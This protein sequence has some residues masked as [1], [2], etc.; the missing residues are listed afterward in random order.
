[1]TFAERKTPENHCCLFGLP[2][3]P[4]KILYPFAK[5]F[6]LKLRDFDYVKGIGICDISFVCVTGGA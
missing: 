3:N 4:V 6:K 5:L 2:G 1:M